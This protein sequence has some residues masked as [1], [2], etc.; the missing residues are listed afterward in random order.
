MRS[1]SLPGRIEV[2]GRLTIS[3]SARATRG[4]TGGAIV[5]GVMP[6]GFGGWRSR[7]VSARLIRVWARA[8]C[9]ERFLFWM[10]WL[11]TIASVSQAKT[12]AE[13]LSEIFAET[14]SEELWRCFSA[15]A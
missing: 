12:F 14:G 8:T 11:V 6:L 13:V 5:T 2:V 9:S 10:V 7:M 1:G 4:V 15:W 3:A